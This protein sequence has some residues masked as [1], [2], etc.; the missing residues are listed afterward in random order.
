MS[1]FDLFKNFYDLTFVLMPYN[2]RCILQYMPTNPTSGHCFDIQ[3]AHSEAIFC[4]T[5]NTPCPESIVVLWRCNLHCPTHNHR[6][7]VWQNDSVPTIL[8]KM[9]N[10]I[11]EHLH[12]PTYTTT[13]Q[14]PA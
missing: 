14:P 1:K 7:H 5:A 10:L 2:L 6:I 11:R 3:V 12:P 13:A 9:L 4:F 8:E